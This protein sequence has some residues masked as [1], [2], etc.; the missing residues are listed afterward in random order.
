MAVIVMTE[1]FSLM[2]VARPWGCET[3]VAWVFLISSLLPRRLQG[4]QP[5]SLILIAKLT[6][7]D[8]RDEALERIEPE[9]N[10]EERHVERKS[11]DVVWDVL[12][13]RCDRHHRLNNGPHSLV[14]MQWTK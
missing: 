3:R 4:G 2:N 11:V 5:L 10:T 1:K 8:V 13:W 6:F 7:F 14:V 9:P 12:R